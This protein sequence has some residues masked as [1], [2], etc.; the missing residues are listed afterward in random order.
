MAGYY[1]YSNTLLTLGF[2]ALRFSV[3]FGAGGDS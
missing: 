1:P 3:N 2:C